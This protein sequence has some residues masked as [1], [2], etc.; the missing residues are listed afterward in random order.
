MKTTIAFL[1]L[2]EFL[3]GIHFF[4]IL[5]FWGDQPYYIIERAILIACMAAAPVFLII[6][7][8]LIIDKKKE[9]AA[10]KVISII[11]AVVFIA[12]LAVFLY[13][14]FVRYKDLDDPHGDYHIAYA[15]DILLPLLFASILT[16]IARKGA[17]LANALCYIPYALWT[18]LAVISELLPKPTYLG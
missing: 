16:A 6:V 12:A 13:E 2:H 7:Q 3:Q 15:F 10:A 1:I 11:A 17:T 4:G 5:P 8:R 18:V 9:A 14:P